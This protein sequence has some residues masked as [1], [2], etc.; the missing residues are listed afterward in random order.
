MTDF[1]SKRT[2]RQIIIF[3]DK[4]RL[5]FMTRAASE[6]IKANEGF[7]EGFEAKRARPA[8]LGRPRQ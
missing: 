8:S 1:Q 4:V 6:V 5:V 7:T 2:D 3:L